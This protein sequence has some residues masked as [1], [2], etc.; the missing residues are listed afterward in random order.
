MGGC[1]IVSHLFW[2]GV[3]CVELARTF[4]TP[5]YVLDESIIRSRCA[6]IRIDFLGKWPG[7]TACYASK[8]FLTRA[9]ARIIDQEGLGLDVVSG[10][11]LYTALSA[12]FPASR[13]ELHGSAKSAEE[14]KMAL[15]SG[16][17][18]IVVDGPMELALLADLASGLGY[19]ADILLRVAPGVR[20]DTHAHI[21]TGQAGSKFGFPL[22]GPML[23][24]AVSS[25]MNS[26]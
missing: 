5:L 20:P 22:E 19:S 10:G 16:V 4:G 25:A 23:S 21:V 6:E 13:I 8:A 3:D 7:T 1:I 12:N 18:R 26:A 24:E 11:E 15:G 9:M 2:G 17:G 14:L